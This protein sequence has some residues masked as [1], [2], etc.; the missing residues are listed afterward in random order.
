MAVLYCMYEKGTNK[1]YIGLDNPGGAGFYPRLTDHIRAGYFGKSRDSSEDPAKIQEGTKFEQVLKTKGAYQFVCTAYDG[2]LAGIDPKYFSAFS[3]LWVQNSRNNELSFAELCFSYWYRNTY[4][5]YND[6]WGG[7]T[8]AFVL[9]V[10]KYLKHKGLT[11]EEIK[12]LNLKTSTISWSPRRGVK[13]IDEIHKLFYPEWIIF[14]KEANL[15][16]GDLWEQ[17]AKD[18]VEAF[19]NFK[20]TQKAKNSDT[21]VIEWVYDLSSIKEKLQKEWENIKKV[22]K[23]IQEAF[24]TLIV[25]YNDNWIEEWSKI[26]SSKFQEMK[27]TKVTTNELIKTSIEMQSRIFTISVNKR[28]T[29]PSWFPKSMPKPSAFNNKDNYIKQY[30]VAVLFPEIYKEQNENEGQIKTYLENRGV[31]LGQKDDLFSD[32]FQQHV[33][34]Y[35]KGL[36]GPILPVLTEKPIWDPEKGERVGFRRANWKTIVYVSSEYFKEILENDLNTITV[37]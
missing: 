24:P 15:L 8:E 28:N 31:V 16:L 37:Y 12:K 3:E 18:T 13:S 7:Y 36:E 26:F 9:D 19:K 35:R 23:S 6:S 2:N 1:G 10:K 20:A 11:D 14:Q 27:K 29:L 30:S 4:A 33:N 22:L 32:Y 21:I 17:P 34:I 5:F 25:K